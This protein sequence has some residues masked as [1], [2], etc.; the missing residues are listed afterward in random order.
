MG[1]PAG[2]SRLFSG[3]WDHWDF[4]VLGTTFEGPLRRPKQS[5]DRFLAAERAARQTPIMAFRELPMVEIKD[6][7]RRLQAGHSLRAIARQTGVD[8]KTIR[9]YVDAL[10]ASQIDLA[11]IDIDDSLVGKLV[12]DVQVQTAPSRS[13]E[14][15]ILLEH[16]A[17]IDGWLSDEKEPLTLTKVHTLLQRRGVEVSYPTL[18]RFVHSELGSRKKQSTVR[19]DDPPPGQEAQIDFGKMATWT[20]PVTLNRPGFLAGSRVW[21]IGGEDGNRSKISGRGS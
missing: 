15:R 17:A 3:S 5:T 14:R 20:D 21:E 7:L 9:R 16:K 8:R 13:D 19:L 11:S 4:H 18:R 2:G 10:T 12:R 6:L 1:P